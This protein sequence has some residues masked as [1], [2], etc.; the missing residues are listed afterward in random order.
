MAVEMNSV[1][2]WCRPV[3]LHNS[4]KVTS[5]VLTCCWCTLS[6]Y[7]SLPETSNPL[8]F[9]CVAV[10]M[11][12]VCPTWADSW[13]SKSNHWVFNFFLGEGYRGTILAFITD[14]QYHVTLDHSEEN[15]NFTFK[16]WLVRGWSKQL[17]ASSFDVCHWQQGWVGNISVLFFFLSNVDAHKNSNF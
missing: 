10:R 4:I 5:D 12:Q 2:N 9:V 15:T 11:C 7:C 14:K 1:N 8:L 3:S 6:L 13:I 16:D 17:P